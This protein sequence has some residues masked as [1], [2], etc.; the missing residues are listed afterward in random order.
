M[1]YAMLARKPLPAS[2]DAADDEAADAEAM[3]EFEAG[4]SVS[5]EAVRAW[6]LSWGTPD[7]LPRPE[8]G[9]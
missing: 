9:D 7:E 4:R 1:F 8:T 2:R 6:I 3:A 5:H